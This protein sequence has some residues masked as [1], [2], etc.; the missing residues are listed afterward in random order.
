MDALPGAGGADHWLQ[1][2]GLRGRQN[3]WGFGA[4]HSLHQR[5]RWT[6]GLY[7]A[8]HGHR[9]RNDGHALWGHAPRRHHRPRPQRPLNQQAFQFL[10]AVL[11]ELEGPE[12]AVRH[13]PWG[14][15]WRNRFRWPQPGPPRFAIGLGSCAEAGRGLLAGTNHGGA[16]GQPHF[17]CMPRQRRLPWHH[18]HWR[19]SP[20]GA[21][22]SG[23]WNHGGPRRTRPGWRLPRPR[24][25]PRHSRRRHADASWRGLRPGRGLRAEPCVSRSPRGAVGRLHPRGDLAPALLRCL[26][27]RGLPRWFRPRCGAGRRGGGGGVAW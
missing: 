21:K 16:R 18:R 15:G 7:R 5:C 6:A 23:P 3:C 27:R 24:P 12:A 11:F 14:Q 25:A 10:R 19:L 2:H 1:Q 20:W 4:R 9:H 8:R 26:R 22:A 13:F 17:G